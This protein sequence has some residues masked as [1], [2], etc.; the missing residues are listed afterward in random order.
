MCAG[1]AC[2]NEQDI[3]IIGTDRPESGLGVEG[4]GQ[5]FD[6]GDFLAW[7]K[8]NGAAPAAPVKQAA[9]R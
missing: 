6:V 4:G 7:L 1:N 2:V 9:R 3:R 8:T 5:E